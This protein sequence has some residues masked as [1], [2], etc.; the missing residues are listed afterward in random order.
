MRERGRR[1][2]PFKP[3]LCQRKRPE[4][5]RS[6]S[7]RMDCGA[8]VVNK[9][10]QRQF[11][12][13]RSAADAVGSFEDTNGMTRAGNFNGRRKTVRA[14]SDNHRFEFHRFIV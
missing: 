5:W 3:V 6:E 10:A 11:C 14:R 9:P 1:M 12:G 13:A 7:D 8:D 4:E 2:N